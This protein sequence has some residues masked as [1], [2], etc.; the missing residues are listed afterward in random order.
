MLAVA[1]AVFALRL[2]NRRFCVARIDLGLQ[3]T[4]W[5]KDQDSCWTSRRVPAYT[6][7]ALDL[8]RSA[9]TRWRWRRGPIASSRPSGPN[10]RTSGTNVRSSRLSKRGPPPTSAS[11]SHATWTPLTTSSRGNQ[12]CNFF[13]FLG[14]KKTNG[15]QS[16]KIRPYVHW[17]V[18]DRLSHRPPQHRKERFDA[19]PAQPHAEA[20]LRAGHG[21][22]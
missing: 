14:E 17:R 11:R 13:F 18:P 8:F 21:A 15:I 6:L 16:Q 3:R 19:R 7:V 12:S 1:I 5:E 9:S 10:P 4:L 20:R 22:D 2:Y